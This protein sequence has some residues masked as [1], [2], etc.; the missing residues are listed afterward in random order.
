MID[1]NR[2]KFPDD[3]EENKNKLKGNYEWASKK[4]KMMK[5]NLAKRKGVPFETFEMPKFDIYKPKKKENKITFK[6]SSIS[7]EEN[8]SILPNINK[9]YNRINNIKI[10]KTEGSYFK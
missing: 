7:T 10:F 2:Y 6:S 9:K 4:F 8:N 1:F 5:F 3:D